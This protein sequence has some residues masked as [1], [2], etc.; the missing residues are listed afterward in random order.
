M[1]AEIRGARQPAP[2]LN[3]TTGEIFRPILPNP[4]TLLEAASSEERHD[5]LALGVVAVGAPHSPSE[6]RKLPAAVAATALPGPARVRT[7]PHVVGNFPT[8][9]L[10][11]VPGMDEAL[12]AVYRRVRRLLPDLEPMTQDL[13]PEAAANAAPP[14]SGGGGGGGGGRRDVAL[15]EQQGL[16]GGLQGTPVQPHRGYH[17]SLSRT[18]PIRHAQ[19]APLTALLAEGLSAVTRCFQVSLA[20]LRPFANDEGTRSFV[21]VMVTH[22]SEQVP[23]PHVSVGWLPGN[24]QDRIAK[25]LARM[26]PT[27]HNN[28]GRP[29]SEPQEMAETGGPAVAVA[30]ELVCSWQMRLGTGRQS[31]VRSEL[32]SLRTQ[33]AALQEQLDLSQRCNERQERLLSELQGTLAEERR[34]HGVAREVAKDYLVELATTRRQLAEAAVL[35]EVGLAAAEAAL[36]AQ[37]T[38]RFREPAVECDD[39][40]AVTEEGAATEVEVREAV[41]ERLERS[42]LV[43][44]ALRVLH[45]LDAAEAPATYTPISLQLHPP[46]HPPQQSKQHRRQKHRS[47]HQHQ[48]H[49]HNPC[50]P[51][52]PEAPRTL[53]DCGTGELLSTASAPVPAEDLL[54]AVKAAPQL[55]AAAVLPLQPQLAAA[56]V[57]PLQ[58]QL[59]A[60]AVLPLQPQLAAAAVL[61]LQPQLAAAA[62]LPLQPQLAAAAVLPLQPQLAAAAMLP[63][64]PQPLLAVVAGQVICSLLPPACPPIRIPAGRNEKGGNNVDEG[65]DEDGTR[66]AVAVEGP[67][68]APDDPNHDPEDDPAPPAPPAPLAVAGLVVAV[69]PVLPVPAPAKAAAAAAAAAANVAGTKLASP[70]LRTRA[71]LSSHLSS[72]WDLAAE[73]ITW[74]AVAARLFPTGCSSADPRLARAGSTLPR[75]PLLLGA[76][77]AATAV[78]PPLQPLPPLAAAAVLPLQPQLAAAAVLPLQPQLAAAAVLPLQ[79]QLAAAAVLPLQPQLAAAAVLPLQPQLAAAAVLPLQPQLAA[80]AVLPLQPQLAAA[81]MLPLQPQPLL[82][83]VAGQVICSL[84]PPACPPIRIPAGRNEK[85]GNNVDEGEDEDGARGAV[86]V[87]DPGGPPVAVAGRAASLC[88]PHPPPKDDPNHDPEDDPAPPA[89]PAPLAVAGLVVAVAPVL[90]VPAPAKAAAAAAAAAANVAGTKLASPALRTRACLSSHLSS[91]WDLAAEG[92]TW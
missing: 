72:S 22:G 11:P 91:S 35:A 81:A 74:R 15:G 77:P 48:H 86:A 53:A 19:I 20:G 75:Q 4:L 10:L 67:G 59:A 58:P 3:R 16:Y 49:N 89:P 65:E 38:S 68:G 54:R 29:V 69:A 83:V 44:G 90:P 24:Q 17:I 46:R 9:V 42:A 71:C 55:A 32:Q 8:V 56:A 37:P 66:G 7:F 63:L 2:A 47:K 70:A 13:P 76:Q 12:D 52:V 28:T 21:S 41:V 30:G 73:G 62:V 84:L 85:G 50:A 60:A 34:V 14:R 64:Q 27:G 5:L 61:P 31:S 82:A 26:R 43:S 87:E 78:V 57:L 40:D 6:L 51:A 80:A 39:E 36:A 18:V 23:M 33:L 1:I 25:A 88:A 92:I 45:A 79:P